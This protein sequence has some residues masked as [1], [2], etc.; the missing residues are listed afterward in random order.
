MS[1][2]PQNIRQLLRN[3]R[4]RKNGEFEEETDIKTDADQYNYLSILPPKRLP[5]E[6]RLKI[7]KKERAV[8]NSLFRRYD[9]IK[10]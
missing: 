7:E 3:K 10:S 6:E 5:K 4:E 1:N 8:R 2:L 9:W